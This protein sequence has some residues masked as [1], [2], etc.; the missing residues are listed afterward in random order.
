MSA[1][2]D[3]TPPG[4]SERAAIAAGLRAAVRRRRSLGV[5]RVAAAAA[6]STPEGPAAPAVLPGAAG[7]GALAALEALRREVAACTA[8]GLWRTRTQTVFADG[9]GRAGVLFIGEAPGQ[10]EDEQ[11][12]PFVGRAGALLT[13][14]IEKGMG[15]A[16]WDVAI[17]NVLK[18]RPPENRD[19]SPEETRACTPFL[20]RQIELLAPRVIVTLGLHAS[21]HV[22]KSTL[23]MGRLRGRVHRIG[24][25]IV[26]PTYHPAYLLRS[27]ERKKDCWQDIQLA[28]DELG[29]PRPPERAKRRPGP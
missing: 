24:G 14:I 5:E 12:I 20:D 25:R 17:A 8:C 6:R 15:L 11:G 23:P 18:C 28:M 29:L 1:R 26:V 3:R 4:G 21:Q 9:T 22:L 16:R 2:T 27:P 7:P 13:D 19:P 10:H